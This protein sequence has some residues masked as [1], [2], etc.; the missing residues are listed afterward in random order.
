MSGGQ[1][2]VIG[3]P[4]SWSA[5]HLRHLYVLFGERCMRLSLERN[6]GKDGGTEEKELLDAK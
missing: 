6:K 4:K 1:Q 3:G 2:S 5:H